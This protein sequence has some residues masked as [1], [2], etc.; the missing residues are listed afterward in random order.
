MLGIPLAVILVLLF[1]PV[2]WAKLV[3]NKIGLCI[4]GRRTCCQGYQTLNG[5]WLKMC[6]RKGVR[7]YDGLT[8]V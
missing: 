6:V 4:S 2:C 5:E 3:N 7:P 8:L 1:W